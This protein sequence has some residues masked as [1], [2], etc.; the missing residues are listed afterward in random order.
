MRLSKNFLKD[1][2]NIDCDI[3]ELAEAMT[4]VGNEYD[5]CGKLVNATN[6]IIGEV[7][8]CTNHPD[9]DHLHV[10]K[11]NIG[12]DVL[13]I[14]C[15]A[16]NVKKDI[17]VIVAQVG[18][19]LPGD[20]KI[21]KSTIRGVESN[22]MLC[23]LEELGIE[24]KFLDEDDKTGIHILPNNAKPGEDPI[25]LL[26][27]DDE[28]ID[29][30]L[31]ANRGDLLSILGMAYEI[32]AIYNKKVKD[33]D[34]EYKEINESVTDQFK[35]K[36]DTKNCSLFLVKKVIDVEIKESPSFIKSRLIASGIRPINNV[37]DISNYV[38]LETGQ[39]LHFYDSDT[40]GDTIL[41]RMAKDNEELTT[42]DGNK[43]TL[44][45]DD[46]VITNGKSSVGLAGVMGG[47]DTE[48]TSNTK[49]I[50]IESA[51]F[52]PI[53]VRLTSKKVL[54]SEA[55]TRFEKGLDP[56]RT[57]M[58][59]E[60][61]CHLL[62]KYANAKILKDT[63]IFDET[64]K[65][66]K[67]IKITPEQIND[68][69]GL[70]IKSKDIINVFN[71][72]GLKN[73]INNDLII[74]SVPTR[75]L[76][77]NIKEDLIEEVGRI[78]GVDNIEGKLPVLPLKKGYVNKE[79][80]YIRN[81]LIALGL[82]EVITYS[83]INEKEVKKYTIDDFEPIKLLD[84]MTED[85]ATLRYSLLPSLLSVYEY[86]K[87]RN[88]KDIS[89]FEIGK[90]FYKEQNDYQEDEHLAMLLTGNYLYETSNN[91]TVDFYITKGII[92]ELLDYLG[93]NGRYNI[94]TWDNLPKE[95]HPGQ[96]AIITIDHSFIGYI[97]RIHPSIN[98]DA[99]YLVEIN[100][101]KLLNNKVSKL[102]Y[103]EF[104]KYP[105]IE[106]DVAFIVDKQETSKEIMDTIKKVGGRLLK[107]VKVFDVYEGDKL[108]N[109]KRSI[110]YNLKFESSEKTLSTEEVDVIFRKIITEVTKTYNAILRD[111]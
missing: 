58:A 3:K 93:Y 29:F 41:V 28:V 60:R 42:L 16:P 105:A 74:V 19:E 9:S 47:Y 49:S 95:F 32:G 103:H 61:C 106:K 51:I 89:I 1:Y 59:I 6:L 68:V 57:Y 46:I 98:K 82:N 40:L 87:A 25:K 72:L 21:K 79:K 109:D 18:A 88:I 27:L 4:K 63:V 37:V 84:P 71:R 13:Q 75:R 22:G 38:M 100:L 83:L 17:K 94:N 111:N 26:E 52:D 66:D 102:K 44:T 65:D 53:K 97:G 107:D 80:R 15:G 48:I 76:D 108:T 34:L 11:V 77:L 56:K 92:E 86:N 54:K 55:S 73:T 70:T 24:H 43:H 2:I 85:R 35:L 110:A 96:T 33:I 39:P 101:S 99:I 69:L 20:F 45:K 8:E 30:D 23:S 62:E 90:S 36:V 12:Q 10:C 81:K 64:T 31:T 14:V 104:G 91:K 78:Y 5:S 50:T 7:L 67:I